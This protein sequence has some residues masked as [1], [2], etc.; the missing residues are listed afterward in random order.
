MKLKLRS[1]QNFPARFV[2]SRL[3]KLIGPASA[4]NNGDHLA[5]PGANSAMQLDV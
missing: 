4:A 3:P 2:R 5:L 1:A